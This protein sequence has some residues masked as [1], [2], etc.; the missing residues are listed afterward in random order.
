LDPDAHPTLD[1]LADAAEEAS[2]RDLLELGPEVP[3]GHLQ[4]R[5]G[6]IVPSDR[7]E[8]FPESRG[9]GKLL[10]QDP[11]EEEFLEHMPGGRDRLG[12]IPRPARGDALAPPDRPLA[13]EGHDE[14]RPLLL[15]PE[16]GLERLDQPELDQPELRPLEPHRR[17]RTSSGE[18][19]SRR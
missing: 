19:R 5:L 12:G 11:R 4:G 6:H 18:A 1:P 10:A 3:E 13:V 14:G 9:A 8:P 17:E 15:P 7:A 2:E 16:A